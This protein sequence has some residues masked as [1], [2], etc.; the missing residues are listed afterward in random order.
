MTNLLDRTMGKIPDPPST[1]GKTVA[2][3][4]VLLA[5]MVVVLLLA[6]VVITVANDMESLGATP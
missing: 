3:I 2:F 5:V 1:A 4:G 6:G